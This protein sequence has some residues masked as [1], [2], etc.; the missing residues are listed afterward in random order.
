MLLDQ[1]EMLKLLISQ[2]NDFI[3]EAAA[4]KVLM[5]LVTIFQEVITIN[6]HT[7]DVLENRKDLENI[8]GPDLPE[9]VNSALIRCLSYLQELLELDLGSAEIN[10]DIDLTV[11]EFQQEYEAL[12]ELLKSEAVLGA[13][14]M[15]QVQAA[16]LYLAT[17]RRVLRQYGK[18]LKYFVAIQQPEPEA[19]QLNLSN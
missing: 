10:I 18:S 5:E 3:Y 7:A 6:L 14:N 16:T 17:F 12:G 1:I 2:I 11:S 8:D 15:Q 9:Q 19:V 4:N 13:I